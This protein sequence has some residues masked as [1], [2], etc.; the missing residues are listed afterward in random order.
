M[1]KGE[2][3]CGQVS[4]EIEEPTKWCGHCHCKMCQHIHG[5]GVVTWVGCEAAQ[6]TIVDEK[7]R[8]KWFSS[9]SEAQRGAC[10]HCGTHLFFRS[11]NWPGELHITR[12]SISSSMDREP[13]GHSYYE[14]HAEW[15]PLADDLPRG[16]S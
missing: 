13:E 16:N 3:F 5:S 1:I 4:F 8:L 6:V 2:C 14:S 9:S 11:S 10:S 15:L 7:A 12:A